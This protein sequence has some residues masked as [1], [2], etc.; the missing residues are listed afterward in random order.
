[1]ITA[2]EGDARDY[3]CFSE[4]IRVDDLE[5]DPTVFD[6]AEELQESENL[7]RL[8]TTTATGDADDDGLHE[9]IF[10]YGA[11]SFS[12]W[13]ADGNQIYDSGSDFEQLIAELMPDDFNSNND[14]N[15]SFDNRS[16]DK[17]PEPEGVTI[18]HVGERIYAF[19]G[20]ERVGGIMVYDITN[21]YQ[22]TFVQYVNNRRFRWRRRSRNSR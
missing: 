6:N 17:G 11:R 20:L 7:G 22:P 14:E 1:M 13:S 18:G 8:K 2:N 10:N 19:I 4:E 21:P 3:D 12:I 15:D 5:L 9:T 16:D